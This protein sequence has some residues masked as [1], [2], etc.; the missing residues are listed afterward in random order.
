MMKKFLTLLLSVALYHTVQA[1]D[2]HFSQ[3]YENAILRNPALTGIFSGDYKAGVNYRT[4][5]SNISVPFQ[6]ML[7]SAETRVAVNREVGDYISFGVA[8][9]YDK[10]G[11][12]NF[13]SMQVY[14]AINYNKVM[15]DGRRSYLSVGFTGGYIQ[16]AF[17]LSKATFSTQYQGGSFNQGAATGENLQNVSLTAYDLGAGLS[18]NSTIGAN[19]NVNY[20]IGMAGFH[21]A[22][23]KQ[24]FKDEGDLLRLDTKWT[25]NLGVRANFTQQLGFTFHANYTTQGPYTQIIGGGM[26]SWRTNPE[27]EKYIMLYA[28]AFVRVKDSWIPTFKVDYN[29]YSVTLS[30][31]FNTSTL[32]PATNGTAGYEISLFV[33]GKYKHRDG[34]RSSVACPRFEQ[35]LEGDG[36]S[37]F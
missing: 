13:T 37:Q 9:T 33:R 30:Y 22:R 3:F 26:F 28:G 20:Y 6:T 27:Q 5:W 36:A 11:S 4:Q 32:K 17:D 21:V 14:P 10:A 7:A 19:R 23:P 1:Q 35:M 25:G 2:I 12:I 18:F 15:A 29:Q 31:D 24:S 34:Y 8:A 16:R